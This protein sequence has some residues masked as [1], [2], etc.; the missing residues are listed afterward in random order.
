MAHIGIF[1]FDA[2]LK[3]I[4]LEK[5]LVEDRGYVILVCITVRVRRRENFQILIRAGEVA[6]PL[7]GPQ[8]ESTCSKLA[9]TPDF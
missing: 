2:N 4:T 8:S 3:R 6:K 7:P 5:D 9:E 1:H